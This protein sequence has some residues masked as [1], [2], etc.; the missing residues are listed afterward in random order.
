M[1]HFVD[2]ELELRL[3]DREEL[4]DERPETAPERAHEPYTEGRNEGNVSAGLPVR[5]RE[6]EPK[7]G[8]SQTRNVDAGSSKSSTQFT[9]ALTSGYGLENL[10]NAASILISSRSS[11]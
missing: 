7:K 6:K 2:G 10:I 3:S 11:S 1:A 4:V 5:T 9:T 8:D